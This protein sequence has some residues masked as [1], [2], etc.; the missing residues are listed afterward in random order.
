M[1][2]S[3]KRAMAKYRKKCRQFAMTFY[4]GETDLL[5]HF[6]RQENKTKYFK[7]LIRKDMEG[8]E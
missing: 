6:E 1:Q 7:D 8:R 4:P 2:E 5:E 3:R